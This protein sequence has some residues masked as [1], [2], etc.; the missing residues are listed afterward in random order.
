MVA[1]TKDFMQRI[2]GVVILL[3]TSNYFVYEAA[4][5]SA[6]SPMLRGGVPLALQKVVFTEPQPQLWKDIPIMEPDENRKVVLVTGAAGFV[7]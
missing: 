5:S 1:I 2:A 6:L 7:G 3:G 4:S